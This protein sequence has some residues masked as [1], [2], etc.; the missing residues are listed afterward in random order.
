MEKIRLSV[1][2]P[3]HN[4][5]KRIEHTLNRVKE[6]VLKRNIKAEILVC[7]DGS[8]DKTEE[9][10]KRLEKE[11]DQEANYDLAK[12][13]FE[14]RKVHF[15]KGD[16]VNRGIRLAEGEIILFMD[17]DS[18]TDIRE[19]DKLEPYF[20]K[21]YD[22]VIGSRYTD[23]PLIPS[24]KFWPGFWKRFKSIFELIFTGKTKLSQ[25]K[26]KQPWI[27]RFM[28][29]GGNLLLYIVLGLDYNDTRCGFKAYS[30][31]AAK[32]VYT[33]QRLDGFGFDDE[34]LLIS[35]KQGYKIIE[36]PID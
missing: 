15:G 13:S 5:E 30:K 21:G 19:F 17:A 6:Y 2:I 35:Q 1:I 23:K 36:V 33:L 26:K 31:K 16:A 9:I 27:R 3:A 12:F 4:E 20:N 24:N 25:A 8:T 32:K 28:A 18:S 7:D 10:V 11:I 34:L 29:R 22:V 14:K